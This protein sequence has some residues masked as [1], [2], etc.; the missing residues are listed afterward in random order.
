MNLVTIFSGPRKQGN[1]A[2]VLGWVEDAA[3]AGGHDVARFNLNELEFRG[4]QSCFAC[5]GS[6][7]APGCVLQDDAQGVLNAVVGA[8]AVVYASPLYMWGVAGPLKTFLDRS[9]CLVKDFM[10][11][12]Y[13]SL[14]DGKRATVLMTCMGP[15]EE[16]ADLVEPQFTRFAG[17]AKYEQIAPWIIP[18]CSEPDALPEDVKQGAVD[19][20]TKLLGG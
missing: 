4:C 2:T 19:L 12:N 10:G 9:M 7:D 3:R 17:Y 11:P 16:N 15:L 6:M 8:D 18:G 5:A 1:T 14:V 13:K 20:A